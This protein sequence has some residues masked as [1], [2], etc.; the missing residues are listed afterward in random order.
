MGVA[1]APPSVLVV[2]RV[3]LVGIVLVAC[4]VVECVLCPRAVTRCATVW[5]LVWTAADRCLVVAH[6]DLAL[7]VVWTMT[8][9]RSSVC[10]GR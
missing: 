2:R 8:A 10:Q 9:A 7:L 5:R 3:P 1:P 4:V 6:V